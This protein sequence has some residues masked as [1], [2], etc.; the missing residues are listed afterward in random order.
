VDTF[1]F[2]V[3]EAAPERLGRSTSP[4]ALAEEIVARARGEAER[5]TAAAAEQGREEGYRSGLAEARAELEPAV[6]VIR[7]AAERAD[8]AREALLDTLERRAVELALALAEKVLAAE[9]AA[10]PELVLDVVESTLRRASAGDR[11][12]L[13][14]HPADLDLVR[15]ALDDLARARSGSGTI[16]VVAERRVPRGGCVLSTP[17]G[18]I[19]ARISEQLARAGDVLRDSLLEARRG[20][21]APEG[22]EDDG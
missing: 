14:V 18:E 15:A 11:L 6:S 8:A 12:V 19:D 5:L 17:V 9:L 1:T 21:P 10:R 16:E 22:G 4:A 3:L 13:N 7:A 20:G 2:P